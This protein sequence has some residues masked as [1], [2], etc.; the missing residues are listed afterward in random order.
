VAELFAGGLL[1]DGIVLLMLFELLVLLVLRSKSQRA[2][3]TPLLITNLG[4]GAALLMTL[5]AALTGARWQML[6]LWLIVALCAHVIDL[7]LR[8]AVK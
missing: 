3:T 1:I 6:A 8:W 7:K 4:S 2:L 5:R